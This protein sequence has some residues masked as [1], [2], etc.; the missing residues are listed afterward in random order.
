MMLFAENVQEAQ[1]FVIWLYRVA[2]Q[3]YLPGMVA[4][5]AFILSH[6]SEP[7]IVHDQDRVD[8]YLPPFRPLYDLDPA[9]PRAYGGLVNRDH[10]YEIRYKMYEQHGAGRAPAGRGGGGVRRGPRLPLRARWSRT[11]STT[12]TT[13]VVSAGAMTSNVRYA[14]RLL[15]ERGIRVGLLRLVAFRP[16]PFDEVRRYLGGRAK[17]AVLDRNMS[18]GHSG[19]FAQ[20]I[21]S[22][23]SLRGAAHR[24]L[25][26]H[27]WAS[28][29]GTSGWRR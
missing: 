23:L 10:Y 22:A 18:P 4:M 19:I 6:T 21:R 24:R 14:V 17:V 11:C 28:G 5:D 12:P 8:A 9:E 13:C 27:R 25:R 1:D 26:V 16:F 15:R 7:L 20:E 2:E 3:V 29:A